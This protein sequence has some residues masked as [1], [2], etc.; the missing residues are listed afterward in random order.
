MSGDTPLRRLAAAQL[1]RNGC[2]ALPRGLISLAALQRGDLR[3]V[4]GS[5]ESAIAIEIDP[6]RV[7]ELSPRE[8]WPERVEEDELGICRLPEEEIGRALFTARSHEQIDVWHVGLVEPLLDQPLGHRRG[9]E[10]PCGD[11]LAD[12]THRVHEL[13]APPVV[14]AHRECER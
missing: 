4:D 7:P 8:I 2:R 3:G 9:S 11:V 5:P 10:A 6:D 12:R 1:L 13:D 14:D